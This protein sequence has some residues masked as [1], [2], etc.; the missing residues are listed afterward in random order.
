MFYFRFNEC[1]PV[2]YSI[3]R[4]ASGCSIPDRIGAKYSEGL[5]VE[6]QEKVLYLI[7]I[8]CSTGSARDSPFSELSQGEAPL[9]LPSFNSTPKFLAQFLYHR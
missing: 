5:P 6:P 2:N 7:F 9:V 8:D 1:E 4:I 3:S